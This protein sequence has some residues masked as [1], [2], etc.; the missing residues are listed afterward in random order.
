MTPSVFKCAIHDVEHDH[1]SDFIVRGE[2]LLSNWSENP[3]HLCL[4]DEENP[5]AEDDSE[6][7]DDDVVIDSDSILKMLKDM[8]L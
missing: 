4:H 8:E 1:V 6:D 7:T 5:E 3:P 2:E